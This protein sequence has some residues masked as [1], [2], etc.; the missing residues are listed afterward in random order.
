MSRGGAEAEEARARATGVC[1]RAPC[2]LYL[3]MCSLR[4]RPPK[5]N[6]RCSHSLTAYFIAASSRS[7]LCVY[8][9][10]A[11]LPAEDGKERKG[12]LHRIARTH[13]AVSPPLS[14][15]LR[16]CLII[17]SRVASSSSSPFF[18]H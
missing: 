13:A 10:I 1:V 2:V 11:I 5:R 12:F 4:A 14:L 9:Y 3:L 15:S 6:A 16:E 17:V 18:V 8:I 7:C